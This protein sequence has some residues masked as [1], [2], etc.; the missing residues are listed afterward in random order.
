MPFAYEPAPTEPPLRQG[1]LLRNVWLHVAG[2]V[3]ELAQGTQLDITSVRHELLVPLN[4]DC[5]LYW[6]Y[7]ERFPADQPPTTDQTLPHLVPF[8]ILCG[9]Y[10]QQEVRNREG[11]NQGVWRRIE[12]N[13]DE[14]YYH[15]PA[16]PIGNPATGDLPGLVL[17]FKKAYGIPTPALYDGMAHGV[18]RVAMIPPVYLHDLMHRFYA[19]HSRVALPE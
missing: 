17:D 15:L 14:R 12:Q 7:E 10:T 6:D 16:A 2:T 9:A 5:D 1:E 11:V 18:L 3:R 19:F 8:V 4:A 13:Q